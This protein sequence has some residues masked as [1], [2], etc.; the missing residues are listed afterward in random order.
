[1]IE[2]KRATRKGDV[3]DHVSEH[4]R[5]KKRTIDWD[6]AQCLAYSTN[7]LQ[8]L[9]LET[10][11]TNLE[12]TPL[13]RCQQLPAPYKRVIHDTDITNEQNDLPNS[14]TKLHKQLGRMQF[15]V[16]EKMLVFIYPKLQEI[17]HMIIC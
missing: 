9:T 3:N 17:D 1:M 16:Y 6:S 14:L 5:L 2:N 12:Q 7:H 11:F 13:N 4:H 10:W 15:L 8:L